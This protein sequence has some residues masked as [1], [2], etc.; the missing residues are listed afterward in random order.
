MFVWSGQNEIKKILGG[1]QSVS[2]AVK[3]KPCHLPSWQCISVWVHPFLVSDKFCFSFLFRFLSPLINVLTESL[4]TDPNHL[5]SSQISPSSLKILRYIITKSNNI[6]HQSFSDN[7]F[8]SLKDSFTS[9]MN[10]FKSFIFMPRHPRVCLFFLY[11]QKEIKVIVK[12]PEKINTF[13]FL[14]ELSL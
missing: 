5:I 14:R 3:L 9:K 11:S 6:S 12:N 13:S 1:F 8:I 10:V 7:P 4:L 2:W